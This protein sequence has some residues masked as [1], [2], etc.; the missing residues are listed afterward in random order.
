MTVV[1][2]G[3]K[4]LEERCTCVGFLVRLTTPIASCTDSSSAN[5]FISVHLR[6]QMSV[7]NMELDLSSSVFQPYNYARLM[8]GDEPAQANH[9]WDTEV[10][11]RL[12][13]LLLREGMDRESEEFIEAQGQ[14]CVS[15]FAA[16][17]GSVHR[18]LESGQ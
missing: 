2:T 17:D 5:T 15:K 8:P 6:S 18:L 4:Q 3:F 9:P 7:W 14:I 1:T 12:H 16:V 11:D 13:A 10:G